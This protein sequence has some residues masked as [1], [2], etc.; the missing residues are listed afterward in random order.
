MSAPA[1]RGDAHAR[2]GAFHRGALGRDRRSRIGRRLAPRRHPRA[3]GAC[4]SARPATIRPSPRSIR[5]AA[6]IPASTSTWPARSPRRSGFRSLSRP[7]PGAAWPRSSA[8]G[9]FDIADGRGLGHARTAEDRLLL[10]A[11]PA[12]RQ[13]ADRALR[14]SG[15][16]SDP[17]RDRPPRRQGDRQSRR[18]QRA[19]RP[20]APARGR[21][22]R[23]SGQS[24]D[25][26]PIGRGARG[27]DDHRRL[28]DPLPGRSCIRASFAP[29]IPI[30]RSISPRKRTGWPPTRP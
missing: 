13:D 11:L 6:N 14:R 3:P 2:A 12:R 25:F 28:R 19:L 29:S 26:R 4:G 1:L 23:L 30:S 21:H 8:D 7:R 16:V 15:K 9:D 17:G 10:R 27:S 24:H 18:D 5:R 20:R 22:R